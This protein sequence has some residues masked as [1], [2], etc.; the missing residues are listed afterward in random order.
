[1]T[2]TEVLM[3][4]QTHLHEVSD[5]R[6]VVLEQKIKM[7]S[8]Y[9]LQSPACGVEDGYKVLEQK[10]RII[11][12]KACFPGCIVQYKVLQGPMS[13]TTQRKYAHHFPFI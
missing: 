1:M 8:R 3:A 9:I 10:P 4:A 11:Q 5:T 2:L 6:E 7:T 13:V 12:S